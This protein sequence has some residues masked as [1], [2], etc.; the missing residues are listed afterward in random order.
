MPHQLRL[1]NGAYAVR[2]LVKQGAALEKYCNRFVDQEEIDVEIR[3]LSA[4]DA[5][6]YRKLRLE[7]LKLNG[8]AFSSSLEDAEKAPVEKTESNLANVHA[9]TLGAFLDGQLVGNVTLSKE[10]GKKTMHRAWVVGVY[11]T[12]AARG[13]GVAHLLMD[14]LIQAARESSEIEQLRLGVSTGN[15]AALNLYRSLG[16]LKYGTEVRS[17]KIG[18]R[19]IDEELMVKFL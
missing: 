18:D 9:T 2:Q 8:D 16:F 14:K 3:K 17:L 1:F 10:T 12:P 15:S 11:V 6:I 13:K 7:A 5:A 4:A 19:Y